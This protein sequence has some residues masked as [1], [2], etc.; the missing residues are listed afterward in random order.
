MYKLT[1]FTDA[2]SAP[3]FYVGTLA[4][5]QSVAASFAYSYAL[6]KA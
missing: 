1:M 3:L 6:E 2:E 5:C 4:E